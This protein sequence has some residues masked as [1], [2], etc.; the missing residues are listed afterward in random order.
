MIVLGLTGSIGSGKSEAAKT[1]RA[2]GCPVFDADAETHRLLADDP[3]AIFD[4]AAMFPDAVTGGVV[5]RK[6]VA[7]LVFARPEAL[8]GLEAVIHPKIRVSAERFVDQNRRESVPL[9]VLELPLLFE[10][11]METLCT[12]ISVVT[13][14]WDEQDQRVLDRPGM[15][16]ARLAA[17]RARQLDPEEQKSRADFMID[18]MTGRQDM[19]DQIGTIV[20][21]LSAR[22]Q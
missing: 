17:I 20:T 8:D 12:H 5:D 9:I 13:V 18:S 6:E 22:R 11:G 7:D 21:G 19:V 14:S 1:F 4:V 2:L 3:G 10:A 16:P 15:T